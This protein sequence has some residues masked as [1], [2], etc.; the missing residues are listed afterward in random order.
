VPTIGPLELVLLLFLVILFF[1]A[2]R[3]PAVGRGVGDT[4]KELRRAVRD[5]ET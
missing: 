2:K 3:L 4:L 1:G 5:D